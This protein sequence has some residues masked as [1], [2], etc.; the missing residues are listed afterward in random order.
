MLF[1][2]PSSAIEAFPF[3][4]LV[5]LF[6]QMYRF[7]LVLVSSTMQLTLLSRS[8]TQKMDI[9]RTSAQRKARK[10]PRWRMSF[11]QLLLLLIWDS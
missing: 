4:Q 3:L 11:A 8:M 10:G 6:L 2:I 1:T 5:I 7:W 9:K